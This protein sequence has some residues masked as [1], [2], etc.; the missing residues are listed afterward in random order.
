MGRPPRRL[1][2]MPTGHAAEQCGPAGA[3][4]HRRRRLDR[5]ESRPPKPST[6]FVASPA[7]GYGRPLRLGPATAS[8]WPRARPRPHAPTAVDCAAPDPLG[9]D[10]PLGS[11]S[12]GRSRRVWIGAFERERGS[13]YI[14]DGASRVERAWRGLP[15]RGSQARR[16]TPGGRD[17]DQRAP[18]QGLP[19]LGQVPADRDA[20]G[21][22]PSGLIA[23]QWRT[24]PRGRELRRCRRNPARPGC[25]GAPTPAPA[26]EVVVARDGQHRLPAFEA[27]RGRGRYHQAE[28]IPG[29]HQLAQGGRRGSPAQASASAEQAH[30]A[31]E[32][33]QPG[34]RGER[35]LP[36]RRVP[37]EPAND[38]L[39]HAPA[40]GVAVVRGAVPAQPAQLRQ[41]AERAHR[42]TRFV[43]MKRSAPRASARRSGLGRARVRRARRSPGASGRPRPSSRAGRSRPCWSRPRRA[44]RPVARSC[45]RGARRGDSGLEQGLAL[46]LGSCGDPLPWHGR[47]AA[48]ALR[49]VAIDDGR[50]A[51]RVPTS[52]PTMRSVTPGFPRRGPGAGRPPTA[53]PSKRQS[54]ALHSRRHGVAAA[55]FQRLALLVDAA[56]RRPR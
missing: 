15:P 7:A 53:S 14:G 32:V 19:A 16:A 31:E 55:D 51:G 48:G 6:R 38:P 50:L 21:D 18:Q 29:G 4:L 17:P 9:G 24:R 22:T 35:E 2:S 3:R 34:S 10:I 23:A 43:S 36:P 12:G 49:A 33:E 26:T 20:A 44:P 30:R 8:M 56:R 11:R 45:Q 13:G 52:M 28:G 25:D 5:A 41:R 39:G 40:A 47:L 54:P 46:D 42:A 37:T 1:S 27:A